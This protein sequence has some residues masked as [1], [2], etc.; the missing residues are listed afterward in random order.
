MGDNQYF[1]QLGSMIT[2]KYFLLSAEQCGAMALKKGQ[3]LA[4]RIVNPV[5]GSND[6]WVEIFPLP[7][8]ASSG[9]VLGYRAISVD[10]LRNAMFFDDEWALDESAKH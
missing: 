5:E 2:G 9:N 7:P 3:G 6:F 1:Q 8:N 4:G 10:I